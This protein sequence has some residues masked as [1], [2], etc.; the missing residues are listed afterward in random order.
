MDDRIRMPF[1]ISGSNPRNGNQ[2]GEARSRLGGDP[3]GTGRFR[4]G[5]FR[6]SGNGF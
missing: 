1:G 5:L 3:P 6:Q 2:L 4:A